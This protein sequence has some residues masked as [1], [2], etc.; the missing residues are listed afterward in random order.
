MIPSFIKNLIPGTRTGAKSKDS[1]TPSEESPKSGLNK[2]IHLL[3]N[4]NNN[5]AFEKIIEGAFYC[6]E[7]AR[8]RGVERQKGNLKG[9]S[10]G[11]YSIL[12]VDANES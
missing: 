2:E 5:G 11:I 12:V 7:K 6:P 3:I 10:Y 1:N 9:W 4:Y 8:Q